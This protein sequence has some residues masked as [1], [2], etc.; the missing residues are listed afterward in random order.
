MALTAAAMRLAERRQTSS[1]GG[2][3]E[4]DEK[5]LTVAPCRP[6]GPVVVTTATLLATWRMPLMN[7]SRVT[8]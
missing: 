7:S 4:T 6:A 1:C 5:A 8:A 3:A 2:S